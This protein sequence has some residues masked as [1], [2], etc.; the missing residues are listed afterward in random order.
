MKKLFPAILALLLLLSACGKES[1]SAEVSPEPPSV[2][3][4]SATPEPTP[5]PAAITNPLTGEA[6]SEDIS[7]NRPYAVML[8]NI[9]VARPQCGISKA[10]IL[11]EVLAEGN[12]T[13]FE[14]IFSDINGVG[15][16]GSMRSSRPYYIE[17]ALAYDAIYVHAGGSDQAYS[18]I[19]SKGVDNID[20]VRGAYSGTTFYRDPTR[21]K[22]GVEHSLFTTSEKVLA[23]TDSLG[24]DT[25]HSGS[26]D[27]GLSFTE[28]PDLGSSAASAS[29]VNVS[30][31][32]IKD[33]SFTYHSDTGKYIGAE[34]GSDIIDGTTNEAVQFKNLL[35]LYSD[36]KILDD[37]G[38]RAFDLD[39][40]GTGH[41]IVNGKTIP[42]KWSHSGTGSCFKYTL[43]DGTPLE[44]AVGKTYIAIVPTGSTITMQ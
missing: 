11:Y 44:L 33:T 30:F 31:E 34:Y 43:E 2:N 7:S 32:G 9:S 28:T 15:A 3:A 25:T 20:G 42:I 6:I 35:V 17:L 21:Q 39:G 22:Y 10:D 41:F 13:R 29:T 19:S 12:I 38:R 27:Y 23:C 36:G 18:D 1:P 16:I 14:A 4:P 5:T 24:Y 40:T 37:Y 26:F 8:N